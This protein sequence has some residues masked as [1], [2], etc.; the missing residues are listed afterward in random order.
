MK[1]TAFHKLFLMATVSCLCICS[2]GC[3]RLT[4]HAIGVAMSSMGPHAYQSTAH[5]F[6]FFGSKLCMREIATP[7]RL[8]PV[9]VIDF[10]LELALDLIILPGQCLDA[11]NINKW[12]KEYFSHLS[13]G[14]LA[15]G[16]YKSEFRRRLNELPSVHLNHQNIVEGILSACP[17]WEQRRLRP[18]FKILFQKDPRYIKAFL[19]SEKCMNRENRL[20]IRDILSRNLHKQVSEEY[21]IFLYI[22]HNNAGKDMLDLVKTM[23]KKGCDPNAIPPFQDRLKESIRGKSALDIAQDYLERASKMP[24]HKFTL[25]YIHYLQQLIKLLKDHGAKTAAEL[26][27]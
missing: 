22:G 20:I 23:L 12:Q 9:A 19:C 4:N 11:K 17:P 8:A 7:T 1:T 24:Q 15:Y 10:P 16:G 14:E 25:E 26:G 27:Q 3:L 13:L 18:C 6:Y 2:T 21:A 5:N